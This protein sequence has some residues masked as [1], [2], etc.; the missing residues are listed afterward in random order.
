MKHYHYFLAF[1]FPLLLVGASC[2]QPTETSNRSDAN[3]NTDT[4]LNVNA[5]PVDENTNSTYE[6]VQDTNVSNDETITNTAAID[7]SEWLTYTNEEYGFSFRYPREWGEVAVNKEIGC[8]GKEALISEEDSCDHIT[9]YLSQFGKSTILL[10]TQSLLFT[11]NPLGRGGYWGDKSAL[12]TNKEYVSNYCVDKV[13]QSCEVF[14]TNQGITVA[15][16]LEE[17]G[18]DQ[19][20]A[21]MYF[22]KSLDPIYFGI[23]LT[24]ERMKT[25]GLKNVEE[26]LEK[27]VDSFYFL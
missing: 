17:L 22:I 18:F 23:V 1:F 26:D 16:S 14:T 8:L 7:T 3:I 9:L 10:A 15:S 11:Q 25:V 24:A 4:V 2:T 12:I 27:L 21:K 13:E 19:G 20:T 6:T 5:E